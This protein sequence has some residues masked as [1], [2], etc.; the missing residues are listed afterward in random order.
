VKS[1]GGMPDLPD[2]TPASGH[3]RSARDQIGFVLRIL[4]PAGA[5]L[6]SFRTNSS[7]R[8]DAVRRFWP[9][10]RC[11]AGPNWVCSA[12]FASGRAKLGSFRTVRLANWV[13]L[14]QIA[15]T[16]AQRARSRNRGI[17]GRKVGILSAISV[18]LW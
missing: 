11:P 4:P 14:A 16:E 7:V 10:S 6:G 5:K 17:P 9:P 1:E 18:S 13:R 15:T 2:L 3:S 8:S 12:H